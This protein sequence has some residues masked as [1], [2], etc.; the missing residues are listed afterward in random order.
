MLSTGKSPEIR[1]I[2]PEPPVNLDVSGTFWEYLY[3]FGKKHAKK[4]APK[5]RL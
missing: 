4:G 3:L 1:K 2:I 5:G